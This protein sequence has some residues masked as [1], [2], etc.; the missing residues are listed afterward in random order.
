[1]KS[2]IVIVGAGPVGLAF[3][4]GAAKLRNVEIMLIER[5]TLAL[6]RLNEHFDTR[7]YAL[8]PGSKKSS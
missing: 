1:L 5:Q 8:S 7:V 6:A 3:A 4:L 2:K